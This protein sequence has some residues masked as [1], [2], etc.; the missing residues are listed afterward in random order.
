MEFAKS[1]GGLKLITARIH[2]GNARSRML[3][4]RMGFHLVQVISNHEIRPGMFRDCLRFE[5]ML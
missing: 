4:L 1:A 5:A 2:C 3:L